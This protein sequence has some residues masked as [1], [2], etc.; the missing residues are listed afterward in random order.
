[1]ESICSA[2]RKILIKEMRYLDCKPDNFFYYTNKSD[3]QTKVYLFNFDTIISLKD[4]RRGKN[5]FCSASFGWVPPEQ[6]LISVSETGAK[7][8]R[9]PLRMG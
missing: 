6:E 4:I 1:M 5:S 9:N 8:Y 3:L 2:I 7:Q